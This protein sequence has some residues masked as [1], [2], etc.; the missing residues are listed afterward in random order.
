MLAQLLLKIVQKWKSES[1]EIISPYSEEQ[2]KN[3]FDKIGKPV[4]KDI[5]QVYTIFE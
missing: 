3:S 2:I 4:S 5:L 1:V